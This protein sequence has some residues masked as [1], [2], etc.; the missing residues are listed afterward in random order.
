M[1]EASHD[2]AQLTL[3]GKERKKMEPLVQASSEW[4]RMSGELE[5]L[6][7]MIQSGDAAMVD[8]AREEKAA[9]LEK[10]NKHQEHLVKLMNPPDPLADR[11][12]IVEIRAGAGGD[13]AGLFAADLFRMYNRF[14]Q[15]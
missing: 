14:A 2:R 5:S 6:E 11:N 3:L 8:L 1:A 10:I 9:L 7:E 12:V 15:R 4:L 13:E